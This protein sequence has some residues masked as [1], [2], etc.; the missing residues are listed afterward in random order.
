MTKK[1]L[2][3]SLLL[4]LSLCALS[5]EDWNR[6]STINLFEGV[7]KGKISKIK[8]SLRNGANPNAYNNI[9]NSQVDRYT[10]LMAA[11]RIG[12]LSN[13]RYQIVK[14]LLE[15][16][17]DPNLRHKI[18]QRTPL[19]IAIKNDRPQKVIDLI[20]DYQGHL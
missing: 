8:R 15:N 20:K 6:R 14:I 10:P 3:A 17:A 19:M 5:S 2:F 12:S 4:S 9:Y 13:E 1:L 7:I 16:D 18:T 11:L